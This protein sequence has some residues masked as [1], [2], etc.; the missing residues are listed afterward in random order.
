MFTPSNSSSILSYAG[1]VSWNDPT[2]PEI[3]LSASILASS[4][5][6][7]TPFIASPHAKFSHTTV[8]APGSSS[9]GVDI[10]MWT[11]NSQTLVLAANMDYAPATVSLS[12]LGLGAGVKVVREVLGGAGATGA[13]GA[14]K[15]SFG[16]VASGAWVVEAGS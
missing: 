6:A 16:S 4:I 15:V 1:A 3:K 2:T 9:L 5:P 11:V 13:M 8:R 10:G 12:K 7:L 14:M